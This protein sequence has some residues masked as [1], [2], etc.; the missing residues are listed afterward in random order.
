MSFWT[1]AHFTIRINGNRNI[2]EIQR[3]IGYSCDWESIRILQPS[4]FPNKFLP[5]GSEGTLM[6]KVTKLNKKFTDVVVYGGLR[7]MWSTDSI[8]TWIERV[9]SNVIRGYHGEFVLATSIKGWASTDGKSSKEPDYKI[10]YKR[11]NIDYEELYQICRRN[12]RANID[13]DNS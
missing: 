1:Q 4:R 13:L 8:E 7:D 6:I 11:K 2:D 9:R 5:S 3:L 12:D 10:D